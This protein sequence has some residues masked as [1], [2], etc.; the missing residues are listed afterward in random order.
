MRINVKDDPICPVLKALTGLTPFFF[1]LISFMLRSSIC[2]MLCTT[3]QGSIWFCLRNFV[4]T[5]LT[6]TRRKCFVLLSFWASFEPAVGAGWLLAVT[7]VLCE[8]RGREEKGELGDWRQSWR[9]ACAP[10]AGPAPRQSSRQRGRLC[11]GNCSRKGPCVAVG[12]PFKCWHAPA[13]RRSLRPH[14][15]GSHQHGALLH[16]E[17]CQTSPASAGNFGSSCYQEDISYKSKAV[18]DCL[19]CWPGFSV[20]PH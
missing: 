11:C 18:W 6:N 7:A 17:A 8:E 4:P 19:T 13:K 3:P 20:V 15:C 14:T 2:K 10:S 5:H 16:N 9:C 12:Q 1:L